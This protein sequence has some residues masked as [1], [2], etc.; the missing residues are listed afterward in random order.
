MKLDGDFDPV[1]PRER[2]SLLPVRRDLLSPL[3]LEGL[4]EVWRPGARDPVRA[5]GALGVAGAA[6]EG[7]DLSDPELGGQPHRVAEE[8]VVLCGHLLVGVERVAVAREGADLQVSDLDGLPK[9]IEGSGASQKFLRFAVGV[10]G[11]ASGPD[12]DRLAA[13]LPDV[14]KRF[15]ERTVCQKHRENPD[16]HS[17]S[18]S[19]VMLR[20]APSHSWPIKARRRRVTWGSTVCAS[21][22]TEHSMAR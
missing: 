5:L 6:G 15:F 12:L 10:P 4:E 14:V 8:L 2:S 19:L 9:L 20:I 3:P 11:V 22:L 21:P 7:Y 16:L 18:P 17:L 13:G 1:L